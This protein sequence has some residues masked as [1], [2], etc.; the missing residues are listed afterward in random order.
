M[1]SMMI[2]AGMDENDRAKYWTKATSTATQLSNIMVA[3]HGGQCLYERFYCTIP[4]Y[5]KHLRIFGELGLL[6]NKPGPTIKS[7]MED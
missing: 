1:H 2:S 6:T 3:K 5:T 7:K 4:D